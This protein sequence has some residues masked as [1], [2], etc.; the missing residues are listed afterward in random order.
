MRKRAASS[1]G[2]YGNF[3][4]FIAIGQGGLGMDLHAVEPIVVIPA[5]A[6]GHAPPFIH[7]DFSAFFEHIGALTVPVVAGMYI[8]LRSTFNSPIHVKNGNSF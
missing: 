1:L 8:L 6:G 2:L 7:V 5:F 3:Y 4:R